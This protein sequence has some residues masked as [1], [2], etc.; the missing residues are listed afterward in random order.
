MTEYYLSWVD[1]S[2]RI[3]DIL[4]AVHN[5][6]RAFNDKSHF[7]WNF[8]EVLSIQCDVEYM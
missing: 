3:T 7:N 6:E 4:R 5:K 8:K 1:F 2:S